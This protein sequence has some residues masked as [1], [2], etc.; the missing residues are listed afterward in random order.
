MHLK[1]TK[2]GRF[3][4]QNNQLPT[5]SSHDELED[6]SNVAFTLA[7]KMMG[8]VYPHHLSR[9]G[10]LVGRQTPVPSCQFNEKSSFFLACE[11]L[12]RRCWWGKPT[13]SQPMWTPLQRTILWQDCIKPMTACH[14]FP[15][16]LTHHHHYHVIKFELQLCRLL[17]YGA[18]NW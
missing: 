2:H 9:A 5:R 3:W 16:C 7:P 11:T 1:L 14:L 6:N 12:G 8:C 18:M 13:V 4:K 10:N 17:Y 15:T